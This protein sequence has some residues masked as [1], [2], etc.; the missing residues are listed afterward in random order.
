MI[1]TRSRIYA[2]RRSSSQVKAT[3]HLPGVPSPVFLSEASAAALPTSMAFCTLTRH[4]HLT[5]DCLN[6]SNSAGCVTVTKRVIF[7]SNGAKD[8]HADSTDVSWLAARVRPEKLVLFHVSDRYTEDEWKEQ[9]DEVRA[10]FEP[11]EFPAHWQ[12]SN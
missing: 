7:R 12:K 3:R 4:T 5:G 8:P 6:E 9:L 11:A 1:R 10:Q 2:L